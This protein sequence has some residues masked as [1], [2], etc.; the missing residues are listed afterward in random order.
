MQAGGE[1]SRPP[2]ARVSRA[3]GG[4]APPS[5]CPGEGPIGPAVFWALVLVYLPLRLW[6][7]TVPGYV[8]DLDF[9]A[10]AA[11]GAARWGW[12]MAYEMTEFDYPPLFLYVLRPIGSFL[13]ELDGGDV[14]SSRLIA[15]SIKGPS[16]V[17]GLLIAWM[18]YRLVSSGLWGSAKTGRGWARLAA[19]AYLWNP[20]VL[21]AEGYSGFPDQIHT[22]FALVA[23]ALVLQ[24][25]WAYSGA[26]LALGGL[27]KPLVAPLVPLLA[28]LALL[29]ARYRG[30]VGVTVGGFGI[31]I[32][33]FSPWILA[34]SATTTLRHV[35]LDFNVMPYTTVQANNLWWLLGGP[36]P[37]D[38][39]LIGPLTPT[40]I[41]LGM[42]G[43][44]L[45]A[46]LMR[47]RHWILE[48]RSPTRDFGS[49]LFLLAAATSAAFFFL[50]THLHENHLFLTLA[51]LVCVAG[52]DR[53]VTWLTVGCTVALL[54]NVALYDLDFPYL[55]PLGLSA[56]S[57]FF[58]AIFGRPFTWLQ[59]IGGTLNAVLVAAVTFGSCL[60]VWR[61]GEG[62]DPAPS[63]AGTRVLPWPSAGSASPPPTS[64]RSFPEL[65]TA[66]FP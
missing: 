35:L 21:W 40:V 10:R 59:L 17:F 58:N 63:P 12:T 64:G 8:L 18:L 41:G 51:L 23:L 2:E 27:M 13:L 22:A 5:N 30:L 19:L 4:S 28:L 25:R 44:V 49:R 45:G 53:V 50:T 24:E 29:R 7:A 65:R 15:L 48:P 66:F 3:D 26:M 33:V 6:L 34:G 11:T 47:S 62:S 39:S 52:R 46:L 14:T 54:V 56:E 60:A 20:A 1:A 16:L 36:Q 32:L 61:L 37:S 38:A 43:L 42:F 55:L 57:P 31:A 9:Y